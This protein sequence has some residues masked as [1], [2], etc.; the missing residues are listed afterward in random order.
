MRIGGRD[1]R[2]VWWTG[3][4]VAFV[5][6]RRLPAALEFAVARDLEAVTRAIEDMAVRGAP[7]IGVLAAYG[8][9]LAARRGESAAAAFDRLLRTRPTAVNLRAALDAVAA[10][11]PDAA[12]RLAAARAWD[13]AEVAAAPVSIGEPGD[14]V[15]GLEAWLP[16][17]P[18]GERGPPPQRPSAACPLTP[19]QALVGGQHL[20]R[21]DV[22]PG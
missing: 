22:E 4:G 9:A 14:A 5:D 2:A 18:V 21:G 7:A 8:L 19:V 6:Q 3:E 17:L 1:L 10:A 16:G 20:G 13:E 11:G 15:R 12:A